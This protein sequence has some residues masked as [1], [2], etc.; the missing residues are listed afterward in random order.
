MKAVVIFLVTT[1]AGLLVGCA[2]VEPENSVKRAAVCPQCK[3]VYF[4][5]DGSERTDAFGVGGGGTHRCPGC[6]GSF[7]TWLKEGKFEHRCTLCQ[8]QPFDCRGHSW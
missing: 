5:S 2:T 4:A 3:T 1:L 6:Q 8:Q 7:T